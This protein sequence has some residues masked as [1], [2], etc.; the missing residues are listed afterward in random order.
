MTTQSITHAETT[1]SSILTAVTSAVK[2]LGNIRAEQKEQ[3]SKLETL[4]EKINTQQSQFDNRLLKLEEKI[5]QVA[6]VHT[7]L[8]KVDSTIVE[9]KEQTDETHKAVDDRFK[10]ILEVI[11]TPE[12]Y[13]E[14]EEL[15]SLIS[16]NQN[17]LTTKLDSMNQLEVLKTLITALQTMQG[18][19]SVLT[20][21]MVESLEDISNLRESN[22]LM[23]ARLGSVD[24]RLS[25]LNSNEASD[26]TL[27]ELEAQLRQL[28]ELEDK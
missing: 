20:N 7:L 22:E 24:V 11:A 4:E 25:A 23:A 2:V 8:Q 17:I 10:T 6:D 28:N 16:S 19:M 1:L 21:T 18:D 3:I 5:N 27:A 13:T 12:D 9:T 14:Y 26:D 15:K